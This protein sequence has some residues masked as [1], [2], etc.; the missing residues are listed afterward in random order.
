MKENSATSLIIE[1]MTQKYL[2]DLEKMEVLIASH[3]N[4]FLCSKYN[5]YI[6]TAQNPKVTSTGNVE[7]TNEI[8]EERFS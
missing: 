2:K 3:V 8:K 6:H 5:S 4:F 1:M 7:K